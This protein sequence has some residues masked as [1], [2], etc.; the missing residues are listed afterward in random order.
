MNKKQRLE[1]YKALLKIYEKNKKELVTCSVFKCGGICF[2]LK[3]N[4][5]FNINTDISE[6]PELMAFMPTGKVKTEYW[7]PLSTNEGLDKR[8]EVLKKC[9]K[10]CK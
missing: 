2:N 3:H 4:I 9:I 6:Y 10:M 7:W 8:I 1:V 5:D